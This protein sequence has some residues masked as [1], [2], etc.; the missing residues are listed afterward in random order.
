[1][2]AARLERLKF[3]HFRRETDITATATI[4]VRDNVFAKFESVPW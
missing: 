1:V 4:L 3:F 2:P